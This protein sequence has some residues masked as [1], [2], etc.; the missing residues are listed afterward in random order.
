MSD[1]SGEQGNDVGT[2]IVG[3]QPA[4]DRRINVTVPAGVERLLYM[5][6][7]DP[8]LRQQLLQ[9]PEAT[10]ERLGVQLQP[11]ERAMLRSNSAD[12]LRASVDALDVSPANLERRGFMQTVAASAAAISAGAAL[13][14][15]GDDDGKAPPRDG[16]VKVDAKVNPGIDSGGMQPDLPVKVDGAPAPTGIR[17]DDA[18][19]PH[20]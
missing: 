7:L 11:S 18:G 1:N 20:E 9:Q 5:A 10:A 3:G 8:E 6:A 14:S 15:C 19:K 17:P 12:Q 13:A 2:T 16:Q 4:R